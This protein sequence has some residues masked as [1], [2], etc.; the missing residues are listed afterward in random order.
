MIK[1]GLWTMIKQIINC[2]VVTYMQQL[3]TAQI[4]LYKNSTYSFWKYRSR[5]RNLRHIFQ[6]V[7]YDLTLQSHHNMQVLRPSPFYA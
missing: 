4:P 7:K 5:I 1:E 2:Y 6:M 3:S